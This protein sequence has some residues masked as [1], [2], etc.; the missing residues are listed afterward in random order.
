MRPLAAVLPWN[1]SPHG[2]AMAQ[3]LLASGLVHSV[4]AAALPGCPAV[5]EGVARIEA[6]GLWSSALVDAVARWFEAQPAE[7]LLWVLPADVDLPGQ[8]LA[9]LAQ[10]VRDSGAVLGYGDFVDEDAAGACTPHPLIDYQT[11]SL[12]DDFDFGPAVLFD[13]QALLRAVQA[14]RQDGVS[15]QHGALYDLRLRVTEQGPVL[16]LSEPLWRRRALATVDAHGAHF[17]YVDPKNRA[18]QIEMEAVATAHLRRI[19]AWLPTPIE[20]SVDD[21]A[22]TGV[23]ASVIIPVRDRVRTVGD[24]ARSALGQQAPF[25]HNVIVVDNHSGDGTREAL[26]ALAAEDPRLVHLV[27]KRRDLGIG[28]C[29]NEAVFSPHCGRFAVQ[30]DSDDLYD[31]ND[32]LARIV[33]TFEAERCALVVGSYSLVDEELRAIPPGLID[34]REWTAGNGHNNALRIHGLGAPRA[35]HVS[36][37]RAVGGF[38]NTSYGEDYAVVLRLCRS[39][40]VGRILDS[41]YWCRRWSGNSD[42]ALPLEVANRYATYKDRLRTLELMAR[43]RLVASA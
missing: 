30:L 38:P 31:G 27:P 43:Q 35:Y 26:S 14:M 41:L 37:L 16:H 15:W 21:G 23:T 6:E 39:Y 40:R 1:S 34:H 19:R 42:A 9:R 2:E 4:A 36:T 10:V 28:G 12:R 32:V 11:G 3:R 20:D 22:A 33:Q 7:L 17:A 29:W 25:D 13:R 5:P 8:A 18:Y 24:A